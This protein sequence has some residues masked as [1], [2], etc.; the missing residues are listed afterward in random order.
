MEPVR[1]FLDPS[2]ENVSEADQLAYT[3]CI[4][5][6]NESGITFQQ[7]PSQP[8]AAREQTERPT[9]ALRLGEIN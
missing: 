9:T 5:N 7:E 6:V 4:V 8:T 3:W 2:R 1:T